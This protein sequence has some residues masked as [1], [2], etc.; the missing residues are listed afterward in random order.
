[1]PVQPE[2]VFYKK[3]EKINDDTITDYLTLLLNCRL[4]VPCYVIKTPL[5]R[6]TRTI[7]T[8]AI[9]RNSLSYG[10]FNSVKIFSYYNRNI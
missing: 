9:W 8:V 1:M 2:K 10:L 3:H 4:L 5:K 7:F 6:K